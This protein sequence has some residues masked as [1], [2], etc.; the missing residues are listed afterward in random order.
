M[1]LRTFISVAP[2]HLT[3]VGR[4]KDKISV[5]GAR[6]YGASL[7]ARFENSSSPPVGLGNEPSLSS[8]CWKA[9]TIFYPIKECGH[10][11]ATLL[12][13]PIHTSPHILTFYDY[14]HTSASRQQRLSILTHCLLL[15]SRCALHLV[16]LTDAL[17]KPIIPHPVLIIL[18]R[19]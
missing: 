18:L 16:L 6:G 15:I 1:S 7:E 17:L 5:N 3:P 12:V 9:C 14:D 8:T 19:S 4:S 2:R 13:C 11:P 10:Q